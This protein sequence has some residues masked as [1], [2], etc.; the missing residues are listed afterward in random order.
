MRISL[1]FSRYIGR[2]FLL[3]SG[4][5]LAIMMMIL[6]CVEIAELARRAGSQ[7]VSFSL[8]LQMA[9]F[10]I[11][12]ETF[13][14]LPFAVL[15]GTMLS[16]SKFTRS[17]ELI[18]ARAAGISVWQFLAPFLLSAVMAGTLFVMAL[19]PLASAMLSRYES[20]ESKY[21]RGKPSLLI[22]SSGLWLREEGQQGQ[23]EHIIHALRVS[24]KE[25]RLSDVTVFVF[26]GEK[27]FTYRIDSDKANLREG[28]WELTNSVRASPGKPS[29]KMKSAK[30]PTSITIHDIQDS[31]A[32]PETISFWQLRS[33][34]DTLEK[35]GFSAL[36]HKMHW[37]GL[38]SLPLFLTGMV[39]LASLFS[40]RPPRQ[41]KIGILLTAGVGIGFLIYFLSDIIHALGLSGTLPVEIA[42]WA[43]AFLTSL[44]AGSLLLHWEDG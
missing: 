16:L 7:G 34:I 29:E 21:L 18:V 15:L 38:L 24:Q 33:F 36:R 13:K 28:Y 40:L 23:D 25:M 9:V 8:I 19:D 17:Q 30:L 2:Q 35:A 42:A 31:F 37:Y 5:C 1:L 43:P 20:L 6:F 3:Q 22:S 27:R 39:M 41:G 32:A 44:T 26:D 14:L 12:S 11:P 4:M 10:R